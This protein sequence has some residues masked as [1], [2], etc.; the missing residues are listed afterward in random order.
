M[1]KAWLFDMLESPTTITARSVTGVGS[2]TFQNTPYFF[3]NALLKKG[4]KT[5]CVAAQQRP[6]GSKTPQLSSANKKPKPKSA[7]DLSTTKDWSCPPKKTTGLISRL[8][9]FRSIARSVHDD[10]P[11][12]PI[13]HFLGSIPTNNS[14]GSAPRE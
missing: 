6:K 14:T 1:R 13:G 2:S 11:R 8:E 10:I 4:V 7:G 12:G 3:P 9:P 5:Y